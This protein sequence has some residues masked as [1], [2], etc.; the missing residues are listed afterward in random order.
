[1]L[2]DAWRVVFVWV[3]AQSRREERELAERTALEYLATD[4]AGRGADTP[5]VRVRQAGE[6]P[7]FTGF[8]GAWDDALW[9][10]EPDWEAVRRSVATDNRGVRQVLAASSAQPLPTYPLAALN[11]R[12]PDRLPADVDPAVKERHL[13]PEE[14]QQVFGMTPEAF[15]ALPA[16]KRQQLKKQ[17]GLF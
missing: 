5:V 4:P 1:M 17:V 14:F 7:T 11:V 6:P 2:L 10:S 12:E 15:G 9:E 3:G 16:W 8:F 13:A